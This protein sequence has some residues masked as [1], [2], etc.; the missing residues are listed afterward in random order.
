M[1]PAAGAMAQVG[2]VIA[3]LG[4]VYLLLGLA[5]TLIIGGALVFAM[6]V[7]VEMLSARAAA[8]APAR[9]RGR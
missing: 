2:A 9:A 7:G 8:R 6:S 1:S 5:W 3:I 4:G